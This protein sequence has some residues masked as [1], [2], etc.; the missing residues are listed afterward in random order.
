MIENV[1]IT[2]NHIVTNNVFSTLKQLLFIYCSL[3]KIFKKQI[4]RIRK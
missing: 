3:L 1:I 4:E 2:I